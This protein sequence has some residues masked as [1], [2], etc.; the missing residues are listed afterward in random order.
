M[1][2]TLIYGDGIGKEV[3]ESTK[4]IIES[5]TDQIEWEVME[6]GAERASRDN[7][8]LPKETLESIR[9]N[10]VALKGPTGT[11]VGNG[12]R[13]VNVEI[14]KQLD[15]Y[16][17]LR[18]VKSFEGVDSLH[19]DVDLVIVRENT[20][21]LY[22]GLEEMVDHDTAITK[23]MITRR[24]SE[25]IIKQAFEY[26]LTHKRD[27]VTVAHKANIMK[28]SDGLFLESFEKISQ[29]Y[30]TIE[31][32]EKIID[33]MMMDLA[34]NP[35]HYDVI[36]A[37]NFYGDLLSDLAAGLVG[38]LGYAPGANIG[39]ECAVF[40]AV[41]GTAPDIAGQNLANPTS[42]ILS[43]CM[44]LEHLGLYETSA[45]IKEGLKRLYSIKK[46]INANGKHINTNKFT[47]ELIKIIK[48]NG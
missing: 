33:A 23:R 5:V 29:S 42:A 46:H 3:I 24:G 14:R 11:P 8:P 7:T 18:P 10:K 38:G 4:S 39:D 28:F 32:E 35:K 20:E 40:E 1:I 13:S 21:G 15:L 34:M 36:V 12:F 9:K 45:L 44:M 22:V 30:P 47:D 48:N 43:G 25:R 2:V 17:N 6:A 27:K 26:A 37:P 41:H 19:R 16:A 31:K